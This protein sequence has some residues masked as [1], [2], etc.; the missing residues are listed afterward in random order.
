MKVFIAATVTVLV[1]VLVGSVAL[2]VYYYNQAGSL[3]SRLETANVGFRFLEPDD[4]PLDVLKI[5]E[6][7]R[8]I[9]AVM[10]QRDQAVVA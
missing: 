4:S 6:V 10:R 2:N 9:D 5:S 8:R 1:F 7:N 3:A